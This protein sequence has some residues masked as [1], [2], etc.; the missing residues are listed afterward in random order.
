MARGERIARVREA[1]QREGADA[2]V[3]FSEEESNRPSVQYL[4]G[5][6]GS[7]AILLITAAERFLITDNRYFLRAETESDFTLVKMADRDPWPHLEEVLR[8]CGVGRLLFEADRLTVDKYLRLGRLGLLLAGGEGLMRRL[9]MVKDAEEVACLRRAAEIAS[10]AFD[11]FYPGIRPGMTEAQLAAELVH[12]MRCR[13]AEQ[14][15]K[16]RF[17]VASGVRG[18]SPHG[19]F[20]DKV[21]A[22]GEFITFDFGAVYQGYVS[23]LTRTVGVGRVPPELVRVYEAVLE[24]ERRTL[25]AVTAGIG[26]A[27]LDAVAR[28]YLTGQGYGPYFT[29]GAGHGIGLELH[30]L[31]LVSRRNP[32]PLP[33]GAVV[34]VEPGVY[35]PGVGGVRIEDDVLVQEGGGEVLTTARREL[36]IL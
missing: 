22:E 2:L 18:A 23:D 17:V 26:G 29:H 13:G 31:P 25:A 35:L 1:L 12:A 28:D 36:I 34:T 27:A 33:A 8:K 10:A 30:E 5:F 11:A 9:R 16:G 19:V 21:V 7:F 6:T 14:P 3:L 4:S 20:T 32:D 24:A 15:V